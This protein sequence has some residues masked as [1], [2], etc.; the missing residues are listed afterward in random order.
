MPLWGDAGFVQMS[1]DRW[2]DT[3][4]QFGRKLATVNPLGRLNYSNLP[5]GQEKYSKRG[6][7]ADPFLAEAR[8]GIGSKGVCM[9]VFT[10]MQKRGEGLLN[11]L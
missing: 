4:Q 9:P 10:G 3:G 7:E 8:P 1:C 6:G 2:P 11:K 5:K